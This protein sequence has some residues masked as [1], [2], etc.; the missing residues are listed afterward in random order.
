MI[1]SDAEPLSVCSSATWHPLL[2]DEATGTAAGRPDGSMLHTSATLL[3][4]SLA[5]R[6]SES[7]RGAGH[8]LLLALAAHE[9]PPPPEG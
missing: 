9:P 1:R 7:R 5:R 4:S 2:H 3:K 8:V 6:L